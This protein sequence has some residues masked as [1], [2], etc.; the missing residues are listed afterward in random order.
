MTGLSDVNQ[1]SPPEAPPSSNDVGR[2]AAEKAP[3]A[4]RVFARTVPDYRSD[5]APRRIGHAGADVA[6]AAP[7][8]IFSRLAN[9]T[10]GQ[11]CPSP[12]SCLP[13]SCSVVGE[14]LTSSEL[15]AVA[16]R[17]SEHGAP[18]M[19]LIAGAALRNITTVRFAE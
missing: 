18:A 15:E 4:P 16:E 5:C 13:L 11:F 7:I 2:S 6:A 17:L 9:C 12:A 3:D 14:D 19:T 8:A 1:Q 10:D